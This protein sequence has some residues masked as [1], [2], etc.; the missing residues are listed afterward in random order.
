VDCAR[1]VGRPRQHIITPGAVVQR[2]ERQPPGVAADRVHV[3]SQRLVDERDPRLGLRQQ[4]DQLIAAGV[5]VDRHVHEPRLR[6][7]EVQQ[8]VCVGVVAERGDAVAR[9]KP[10]RQQRRRD[11]PR[12][13]VELRVGPRA[14]GERQ[15]QPI[16]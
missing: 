7:A 14:A 16:R 1:R 10:S 9:S 5:E 8:H 15:R 4:V 13:A 2:P 3:L 12:S 6:A 11:A